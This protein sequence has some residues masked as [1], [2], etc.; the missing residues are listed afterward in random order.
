MEEFHKLTKKGIHKER[1]LS[2]NFITEWYI[3]Q[4]S[5]FDF[6]SDTRIIFGKSIPYNNGVCSL[7]PCDGNIGHI[8]LTSVRLAS[9]GPLLCNVYVWTISKSFVF[10]FDVYRINV[11]SD[12]SGAICSGLA[13]LNIYHK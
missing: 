4:R 11:L 3:W 7:N 5:L 8:N 9:L 2:L 6:G 13:T 10:G 1:N 12:V